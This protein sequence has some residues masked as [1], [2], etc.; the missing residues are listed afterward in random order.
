MLGAELGAEQDGAAARVAAEG[1]AVMLEPRLAVQVA[2]VLHELVSNARRHG[3]LARPG[4]RVA[5]D[6]HV[7]AGPDGRR[8]PARLARA[9]R[10]PLPRPRPAPGFGFALIERSLAADGGTAVRR[11]EDGG[12]AWEIELPL[13]DPPAMLPAIVP[14]AEDRHA[15]DDARRRPSTAAA[16]S[17]SRTSRWWRSRSRPSWPTP[18]RRWSGRPARSRRRRG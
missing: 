17:S 8:L 5:V 12:I 14:G 13:P 9:G 6:W 11:A 15:H 10:P 4:G 2:L 3:A 1:P 18:A 7:E 16:C